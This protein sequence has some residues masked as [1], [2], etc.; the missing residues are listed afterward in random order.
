MTMGNGM[1]SNRDDDED[2]AGVSNYGG[3][4]YRDRQ[5]DVTGSIG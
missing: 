1:D 2:S 4:K 5:K 3:D